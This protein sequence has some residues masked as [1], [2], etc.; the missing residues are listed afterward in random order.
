MRVLFVTPYVPS[1]IRVRPFHF[2]Q[3]L[4]ARHEISLVSLLCDKYEERLVQ[5]I[6]DYCVSVD[7]VPLPRWRAYANCLRALPSRMPLR[8]AYY[9]S[10]EFV[11]RILQVIREHNI[12]IVHGEL[13]KVV[14]SLQ[15]VLEQK[16]IPI[17]YD[18]VDCISSYL[19]QCWKSA[20][21]PLSKAFVY[22]E[23]QKM[24]RY[25][26]RSM[27]AF[28]Q[29]AITSAHDR[30]QMIALGES[31]RHIQVVPNG[32][33]TTYFVPSGM[34]REPDTI[35]FCAKMD[36][37]PNTQAIVSFYREVMPRIWAR[38]PQVRLTIVGNNPPSSVYELSIDEHVTV[39]GYVPDIRPYLGRAAVAISP[40]LVAAGM[41][42]KVLE[43]LA[44]GTPLVATPSSCRSL[45]VKD[46]IHLLIA[47]GAQAYADAILYL[48][49]NPHLAY[50]LGRNGREYVEEHHSWTVAASRL[51]ELYER[52]VGAQ[53]ARGVD[54]ELTS[55]IIADPLV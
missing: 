23:L 22:S 1:R 19:E 34:P 10:P 28:D 42:N 5:E 48:L 25:E 21:S 16:H 33:D 43:A 40:L 13:I 38:R 6:A 17:I 11:Q 46:G 55:R 35:V 12:E 54:D 20:S 51:S 36:Y 41:Q 8:V 29:V 30:E 44:M 49:E 37:Y 2:I 50:M 24:R 26:P 14:P 32:V 15:T 53:Q 47:R 39:T 9:R 31:P 18:S 52:A 7:L 27:G 45:Q 4:S 3:S